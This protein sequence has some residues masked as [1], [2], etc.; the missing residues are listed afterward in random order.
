MRLEV[1]GEDDD[2]DIWVAL[3]DR[4]RRRKAF[5]G[6][7]RRHPDVDHGDVRR[8]SVNDGEERGG[9]SHSPHDVMASL[10]QKPRE[11]LAKER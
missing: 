6:L 7:R 11:A 1:V 10:R 8:L 3:A 5:V 9:V 4:D 2:T